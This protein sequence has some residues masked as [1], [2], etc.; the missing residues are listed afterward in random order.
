[1]SRSRN[2][3]K[4]PRRL[5]PQ[6]PISRWNIF[7]NFTFLYRDTTATSVLSLPSDNRLPS[8]AHLRS[9]IAHNER[10]TTNFQTTQFMLLPG[11]VA[12]AGSSEKQ[13]ACKEPECVV[14]A[15]QQFMI[16]R[17]IW[18]NCHKYSASTNN[19]INSNTVPSRI[20][21]GCFVIASQSYYI[22]LWLGC[23][24][25]PFFTGADDALEYCITESI[26]RRR[27]TRWSGAITRNRVR[28]GRFVRICHSSRMKVDDIAQRDSDER[29]H[30][31]DPDATH[32]HR[33]HVLNHI[34]AL[35]T[36]TI[37]PRLSM[38]GE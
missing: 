37:N 15:S 8:A 26:R 14:V 13:L 19:L 18:I 36:I 5:D 35:V 38:G 4:C 21:P 30:T 31:S 16:A 20:S 7:R 2:E 34:C 33:T 3:Q 32:D 25:L 17:E 12:R 24:G 23:C 6:P 27:R 22:A 11:L 10:Q 28:T 1:M 29:K 9:G